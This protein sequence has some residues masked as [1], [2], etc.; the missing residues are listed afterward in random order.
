MDSQSTEYLYSINSMNHFVYLKTDKKCL[1]YVMNTKKLHT[2][3]EMLGG[4]YLC[5]QQLGRSPIE[6]LSSHGSSTKDTSFVL[7]VQK[8]LEQISSIMKGGDKLEISNDSVQFFWEHKDSEIVV[9][10]EKSDV[11]IRHSFSVDGYQQS[12]KIQNYIPPEKTSQETSQETVT[13]QRYSDQ[14]NRQQSEKSI[15][16]N[17]KRST[18]FV[19]LSP[20]FC[21]AFQVCAP[22]V[23]GAM[24][25]GIASVSLVSAMSGIDV[26]SFFGSGGLSLTEIE[27]ALLQ[28][29]KLHGVWGVNL[30]HSPYEPQLEED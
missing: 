7:Q 3:L 20:R 23:G 21:S 11:K 8:S 18:S 27:D 12:Q 24:A 26:L 4:N 22:Y 17:E 10:I 29:S 13:N 1:R 14:N 19:H 25:G 30:L 2:L 6:V 9:V 16:K 5:L 15:V 28:L